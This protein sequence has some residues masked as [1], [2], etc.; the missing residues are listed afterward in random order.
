MYIYIKF[1]N[2]FKKAELKIISFSSSIFV[3]QTEL[4]LS[5]D[6]LKLLLTRVFQTDYLKD[7]VLTKVK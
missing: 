2:I 4:I 7:P 1:N 6:F 3:Y 5:S